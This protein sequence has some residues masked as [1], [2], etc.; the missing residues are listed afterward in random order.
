LRTG[1]VEAQLMFGTPVL[2]L[3]GMGFAGLAGFARF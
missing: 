3:A 2:L 1:I